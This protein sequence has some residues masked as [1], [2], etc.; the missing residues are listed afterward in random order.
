M[1]PFILWFRSGIF[2]GKIHILQIKD[3][4]AYFHEKYLNGKIHVNED[5][6]NLLSKGFTKVKEEDKRYFTK[7]SKLEKT[8][9][10]KCFFTVKR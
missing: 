6:D 3:I 9:H 8:R 7:D 4:N 5:L 2:R 10:G 1:Q